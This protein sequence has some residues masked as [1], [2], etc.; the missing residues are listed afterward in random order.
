MSSY[1]TSPKQLTLS[2][3]YSD[4][5]L[6]GL[7]ESQPNC[8]LFPCP[9]WRYPLTTRAVGVSDGKCLVASAGSLLC[10]LEQGDS[11][12]FSWCLK[13]TGW[14]RQGQPYRADPL[15]GWENSSEWVRTSK[16]M[17]SKIY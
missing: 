3:H 16:S 10:F 8:S 12:A 5:Y 11:L 7:T 15:W 17:L 9:P 13:R 14:W 6:L 2:A 1:S 4:P